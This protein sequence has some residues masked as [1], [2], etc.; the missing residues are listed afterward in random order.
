M[1]YFACNPRISPETWAKSAYR[2][3][4]ES[5]YGT[6]SKDS[7]AITFPPKTAIKILI[8]DFSPDFSAES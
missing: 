4:G 5:L 6:L 3:V 2:A 8:F 1:G 7:N